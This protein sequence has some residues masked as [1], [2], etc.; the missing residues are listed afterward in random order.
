MKEKIFDAHLHYMMKIPVRESVMS[1]RKIFALENVIGANFLS[2]PEDVDYLDP[3]QN[4]K[5]LYFKHTLAPVVYAFAGVE[6]DRSIPYEAKSDYYL[7]QIT[8]YYNA[9]FDGIKMY[10]GKPYMR[11]AT[12]LPLCDPAYDAFYA[13]AEE[14]QFPIIMH[15]ADPKEFWDISQISEAAI[16]RGWFCDDS[17]PTYEAFYDEVFGIMEKFPRLRLTLA[18]WGFFSYSIPQAEKFLSYPNTLIDT[19]PGGEQI[20]HMHEYGIEAWK[21]FIEKYSHRILYGTDIENNPLPL[22]NTADWENFTFVRSNLL[23][24]FFET[25]TEHSYYN[26]FNYTGIALAKKYLDRIYYEN[27]LR[28]YPA[29]RPINYDYCFEKIAFFKKSA[30]DGSIDAHNLACMEEDFK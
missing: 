30:A 2:I 6:F 28:E 1:Y 27:A 29:P 18:H 23:R 11:R 10:A 8:E 16:A 12:G 19:T 20:Q 5:A 9:G 4:L 25:D 14:K 17:Y 21:A 7:N 13:F 24:N 3:Q 15:I 26:N 22:Q